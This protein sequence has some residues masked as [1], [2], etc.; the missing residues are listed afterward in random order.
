MMRKVLATW[1]VGIAAGAALLVGTSATLAAAPAPSTVAK[2]LNEPN[3]SVVGQLN[4]PNQS[5]VGQLNE[6]NQSVIGQMNEPNQSG[7]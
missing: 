1:A 2:Q 4:E 5:V 7:Q 6:P 3:Q